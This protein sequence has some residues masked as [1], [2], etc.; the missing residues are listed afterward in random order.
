MSRGK[1]AGAKSEATMLKRSLVEVEEEV[2]KLRRLLAKVE[3]RASLSTGPQKP[4]P[5]WW[6]F[7]RREWSSIK[8]CSSPVKMLMPRVSGGVRGK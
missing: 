2:T 3:E 5:R 4:L 7:S 1:L 6:R 8:S